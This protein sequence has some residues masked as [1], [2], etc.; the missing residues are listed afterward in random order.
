MLP[1]EVIAS[2]VNRSDGRRLTHGPCSGT[3]TLKIMIGPPLTATATASPVNGAAPLVVQFTGQASGGRDS[4]TPIDTT[5]DHLGIVTA[6]VE[7]AA[8][9]GFWEVATNAF[10]NA[11]TT[12]W[13]DFADAYPGTRQSWIQYQYVSGLHYRVSRYTI[14]LAND[15]AIYL[16]R[17][18]ADW[19]LLGSNNIGASW[20]TLDIRT[21][22]VFTANFQKLTCNFSNPANYNIYRFQIDRVANPAQA[23]AMQ[24]AEL[25]LLVLPPAQCSYSWSFGDGTTSTAQNPQHTCATNGTYMAT[26]IVSDGLSTAPNTTAV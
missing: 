16:E 9:A 17:N 13:L 25:E 6:V 22:Q 3:N 26:L 5:D 19:R 8:A 7:N 23:V 24:L 1:S 14:S 21:N 12:K 11:N 4:L 15:A 18:P 10:D 20:V 2:G